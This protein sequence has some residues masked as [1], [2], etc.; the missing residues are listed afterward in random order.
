MT[1]P[2][3]KPEPVVVSTVC[4]LC[5]QPWEAHG[6]TPTTLD[7]IRLLKALPRVSYS[8]PYIYP[9]LTPWQWTYNQNTL[10]DGHAITCGSFTTS[11]A[12]QVDE[13]DLIRCD[14]DLLDSIADR[15]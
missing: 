2:A 6:A 7:C 8:Q 1:K 12:S 9:V 3:P 4:S 15:T 11:T 13:T 10:N 14:P 5:D